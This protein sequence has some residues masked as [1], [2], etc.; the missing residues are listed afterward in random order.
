MKAFEKTLF[1]EEPKKEAR[2]PP[3]PPPPP[4]EPLS[5][6]LSDS[7]NDLYTLLEKKHI[8]DIMGGFVQN[9]EKV[10][11]VKLEQ[12][13]DLLLVPFDYV[14]VNMPHLLD[15]IEEFRYFS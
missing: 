6:A 7:T 12:T 3:T 13:T 5:S 10:L 9:G 1:P 11:L 2:V 8:E 4:Q 15:S 14:K